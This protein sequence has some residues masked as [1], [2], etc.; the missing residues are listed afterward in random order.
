MVLRVPEG[1]KQTY[2]STHWNEP[3]VLAHVRFNDRTGPNG[4]KIL[5]VEE[6]QSDWHREGRESGYGKDIPDAPF[7]T[8]W[9]ELVMKRMLRHAAENGYEKLAWIDGEETVKRYDLSTKIDYLSY[10]K[11]P[12][13]EFTKPTYHIQ[14]LK[15]GQQVLS[16]N[17]PEANLPGVV[18]KEVAERILNDVGEQ[19]YDGKRKVPDTKQLSG[20]DLKVGGEWAYNL[21]DRMIPQFMKK[22]GRKWGAK[23][24]DAEISLSDPD[25][26]KMTGIEVE[27]TNFKAID[28]TPAMTG[29]VMG[30]QPKFMPGGDVYARPLEVI[31][32]RI[33]ASERFIGN[34]LPG[35]AVMRPDGKSFMEADLDAPIGKLDFTQD[36]ID[37][38]FLE[39]I[40]ESGPAA[41]K[42]IDELATPITKKNKDGVEEVVKPAHNM[43]PP[44]EAHWLDVEKLPNRDRLWYEISAEA[45]DTSFPDH[46]QQQLSDVMDMTAATSPLA[47]P[48]YNSRVMISIMSEI[49][50][51]E[52]IT[53]PAVVQK[54]VMDVVTGE[55]GKAEA[56]KV[57]SFGQTFKFLRGL[58]DD[59][60]LSTNDRQ[61]AA[62]FGI[63]D[64]AFGRYP[65]LYEVV[66]RWFNK[67]RD[68][69]NTFRPGDPNGPFQSYQLQAPSWVQTRAEGQLARTKN[70][71]EAEAF[72]G[73][74]YA[75]AFGQ[76]AD[77]L[78]AGGIKVG[79]DPKTGLPLF[80][81]S[82][83]K[84]P[85]VTEILM[86][87]AGEFRRDVFG[88]MEIGTKLNKTGKKFN[89]LISESRELGID[90]NL[91]LSDDLIRRHMNRLLLRE[92]VGEQKKPSIL[93]E[94][95]RS[96]GEKSADV[97]RIEL[98]WGT[99]E[100]DM[101]RNIRIPLKDVPE[102][103]REAYLAVLGEAYQQAA[104]AASK[105]TDTNDPNPAT[106][107]VFLKN[108]VDADIPELRQFAED[109][110][111][112]GHEANIQ[113]RPN[114]LVLDIHPKFTDDGGQVPIGKQ[115]LQD[116]VDDV[117][118]SNVTKIRGQDYGSIYT[119]A[120]QYG[121]SVEKW[122]KI[123][124]NEAADDIQAITGG[125]RT[126]ARALARGNEAALKKLTAGKR[127]RVERVGAKRRARLHQL[128]RTRRK[129]KKSVAAFE[130]DI[131]DNGIPDLQK[132]VTSRKADLASTPKPKSLRPDFGRPDAQFMPATP[133]TRTPT[134]ATP[135]G[136]PVKLV[137][138]KIYRLPEREK[139]ER[140]DRA[141]EI[142]K[143]FI[144]Q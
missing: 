59:P 14:A 130:K 5:F 22:Y 74:A 61:V 24:E 117:F 19:A 135:T 62:S 18:G 87:L 3:N 102:Q 105:F 89:D 4:E 53:T 99:F 91:K 88:T 47:D 44:G 7:K 136:Q 112:S 39:S 106:Y 108:V 42:A 121:S 132:R 64:A 114:G 70:L 134:P 110:S 41:Q 52:P 80:D 11:R 1:D 67:M 32:E 33:P 81:N 128:E 40:S 111:A 12:E 55:F 103:Y 131:L 56:R 30:G 49:A 65:V 140:K 94:L 109:L 129:L 104:Q 137:M 57:G 96:F 97:S 79:T 76:V 115:V 26:L 125:S 6:V 72:E 37:A 101:N 82:V 23:V 8:S 142:L 27:P 126:S 31:K 84:D 95:A 73:D 75:S 139:E 34:K 25:E 21:Y 58:V 124:E 51:N 13:G 78:R 123:L 71:T 100:G 17:V 92:K 36:K 77:A 45:M 86:P 90:K 54:S 127:R 85:R 20:L 113:L 93:T 46:R 83:L 28:I 10:R 138:D 50:R 15:D 116:L 143:K 133:G 43:R 16:K 2:T 29:D 144:E 60:P 68:N 35:K 66:A 98:G 122:K 9:H 107:T 48:N 63:P 118:P 69:A 120:S 119:M 38:A 141:M